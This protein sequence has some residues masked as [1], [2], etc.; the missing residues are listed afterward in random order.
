MI[1][2]QSSL[3]KQPDIFETYNL[4]IITIILNK[5]YIVY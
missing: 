2:S 4:F 3:N 5:L 1:A